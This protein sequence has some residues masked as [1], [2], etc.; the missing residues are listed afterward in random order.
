MNTKVVST[1]A[2]GRT[3]TIWLYTQ[4][5][6]F[7]VVPRWRSTSLDFMGKLKY[8]ALATKPSFEDADVHCISYGSKIVR[9]NTSRCMSYISVFCL[10][11][12]RAPAHHSPPA[13]GAAK[14]LYTAQLSFK[15]IPSSTWFAAC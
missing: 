8:R 5:S 14:L 2:A 13:N 7:D 4:R 9:I 3:S 15:N 6:T 12:L 11:L 1:S 10:K